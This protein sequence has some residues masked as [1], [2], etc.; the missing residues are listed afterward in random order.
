MSGTVQVKLREKK[1]HTKT[2]TH[3]LHVGYLFGYT[4]NCL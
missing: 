2:H 1:N 4:R 3:S